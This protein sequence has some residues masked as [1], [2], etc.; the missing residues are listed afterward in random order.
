VRSSSMN[1]LPHQRAQLAVISRYASLQSM[2]LFAPLRLR[3][4]AFEV[5]LT[6][7]SIT[8][9]GDHG[10]IRAAEDDSRCICVHVFAGYRKI[11]GG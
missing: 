5:P 9:E 6:I 8:H 1:V 7:E 3:A 2:A 11:T 10:T 4:F